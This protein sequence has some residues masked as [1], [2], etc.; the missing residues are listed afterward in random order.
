M[1]LVDGVRIFSING[2]QTAINGVRKFRNPPFWVLIFL[3]NA[4]NK[5]I[6]L[7]KYLTTFITSSVSFFVS[8][9]PEHIGI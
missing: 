8:V 9:I 6:L 1:T 3:V 2:K 5:I 7:S 4:F